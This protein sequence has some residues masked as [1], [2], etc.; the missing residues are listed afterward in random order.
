MKKHFNYG[1]L[2]LLLPP[3]CSPKLSPCGADVTGIRIEVIVRDL[4]GVAGHRETENGW[5][6]AAV[7]GSGG[8]QVG[9]GNNVN[10][11]DN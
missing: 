1:L 2:P 7:V 3:C 9:G 8:D 11:L 6:L 5:L 4:L 10:M